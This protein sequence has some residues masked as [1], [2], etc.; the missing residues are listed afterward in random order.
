MDRS[1]AWS[2]DGKTI[3]YFSDESGEYALHIKPQSGAG[4]TKKIALAG[5]SA[6]YFDPKWSPDSKAIAF[7]DNHGQPVDGRRRLRQTDQGRYQLSLRS[8]PQLQLVRR[9]QVDRASSASCPTACARSSIYSVESGKSVQITDGMSDARHPAFDRDGQYLYF[10]ASTN[11]GPT[12]SGLDMTSDEH[13]VTSSVYLAVL[14]NNIASPLAPESDEEGRAASGGRRRPRR[15]G[16]RRWRSSAEQ[17]RRPEAPPK[18]VRIDFDKIQQR[19]LAA[20]AS[21]ARLRRLWIS[22]RAGIVF[23]LEPGAGGGGRGGFGGGATLTRFDL[24]TR[25]SEKL[26]DGVAGFDLSANGEKMLV[27]MGAAAEARADVDA[28]ASPPLRNT[29]SCRPRPPS[30]RAM[31]RSSSP[32]SK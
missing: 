23:L 9:F 10:T 20:A 1:P 32:T 29:S 13:E 8:E 28:E 12:S 6:F 5:K 11:Y 2:P 17:P 24:K 15:T 14:P 21:G 3:A 26:A 30:S 7:N 4:E 27:R 31:A 22:G 25:K 16:R 19:I 18:P